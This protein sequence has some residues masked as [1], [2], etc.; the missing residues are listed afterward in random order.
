[1]S[2]L[3]KGKN[4]IAQVEIDEVFYPVFCAKTV[5]FVN[6]QDEIEV[7]T[8]NSSISREFLPGMNNATMS[9]GGVLQMIN[10]T[11]VGAGYLLQESI[12]RTMLNMRI[13]MTDEEGTVRILS[14]N[15]FVRS[16]NFSRDSGSYAQSGAEFRISGPISI[17]TPVEPPTPPACEL[18]DTLYLTLEEGATSVQSN[19]LIPGVGETITVIGVTRSGATYYET[20]GTPGSL[21]FHYDSDSG[22]VAWD[23]T[24]PGNTGGEPV[25]VQYKIET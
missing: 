12:R 16:L 10:D 4:M 8:I 11:K 2:K 22:T 15:A 23:A 14:F 13:Y 7:T 21:E 18:E 17:D 9:C 1:M 19:D 5:E 3:I 20:S 6:E 24:N 25:S